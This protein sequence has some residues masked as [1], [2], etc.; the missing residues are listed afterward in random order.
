MPDKVN[1]IKEV[2]EWITVGGKKMRVDDN[3]DD[4]PNIVDDEKM[5]DEKPESA[6]GEKTPSARGEKEKNTKE[7]QKMYKKRF[8]LLKSQFKTRDEVVFAEYNKSGV[9]SG[10]NGEKVNIVSDGRVYPVLKNNVFKK[11]ELLGD[12]HW[13]SMTNV[14][15][16]Q[17]LKST[18]LPTFYNKQNWGNLSIEIRTAL[19]KGASPAGMT[20]STSGVHNPIYNPI[21][22]EKTVSDTI[23]TEMKRQHEGTS[24]KDEKKDEKKQQD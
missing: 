12:R 24:S 11:S 23:D 14:D 5:K 22:E 17:V 18:N 6:G 2:E 16:V 20:T 4:T 21:N 7:A 10:I 8:G 15:R 13:D 1:P 9:I 3:D 19:L